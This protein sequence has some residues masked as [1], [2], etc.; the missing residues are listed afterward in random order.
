VD[1]VAELKMALAISER[2]KR[3]LVEAALK[4]D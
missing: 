3:I 4:R 2:E 1:E